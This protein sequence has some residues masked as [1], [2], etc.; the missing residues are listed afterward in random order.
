[1]GFSCK[2]STFATCLQAAASLNKRRKELE[3]E[4]E[5]IGRMTAEHQVKVAELVEEQR[6]LQRLTYCLQI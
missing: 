3:V 6:V 4:K 2:A 1:M 5:R